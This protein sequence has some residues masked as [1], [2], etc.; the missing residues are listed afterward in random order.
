MSDRDIARLDVIVT[1]ISGSV[2]DWGKIAKLEPLFSRY[3]PGRVRMHVVDSHEAARREAEKA[4]REGGRALVSAGG[5]GTFNRVMQG[6]LDGR[7][8][9]ES[10]RL[11][12]LRK[13][14]ADLIGKA[15]GI[16]DVVE[17]AVRQI[18]E[19]LLADRVVPCDVVDVREEGGT[20]SRSFVGFG[21]LEVVGDIPYFTE[22]RLTKYYK[23]F[24][25]ALFGDLG[26]FRVGT[27]LA[28]SGWLL[29]RLTLRGHSFRLS[30]DGEDL[31]AE[32]YVSILLINGDLGPDMPYCRGYGLGKGEFY[33]IALKDVGLAR[34]PGQAAR[35]FDGS[36]QS[37]P[38][39]WGLELRAIR[40]EL[41]AVPLMRPPRSYRV[42]IDGLRWAASAPLTFRLSGKL[43]LIPGK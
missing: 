21:G 39:R 27:S 22:S 23:G 25:G 34:L 24:L 41:K 43:K 2:K 16:S 15:L 32:R 33:L 13:G 5:A 28:V 29:R 19:G 10:M 6:V 31:P 40:R 3:F 14:S 12:F 8:D 18:S 38:V 9:L 17:D 20:E 30:V 1:T 42:N 26:P 36:I 11:G 7:A 35:S 37:D 4:V